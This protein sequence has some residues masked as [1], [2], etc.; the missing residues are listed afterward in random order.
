MPTTPLPAPAYTASGVSAPTFQVQDLRNLHRADYARAN[1]TLPFWTTLAEKTAVAK[2]ACVVLLA[3][4][5]VKVFRAK[6]DG[7]VKLS[8]FKPGSIFSRAAF[9]AARENR[10]VALPVGT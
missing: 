10:E 9:Q 2:G 8:N 1:R 6:P 7:K 5:T 3:D 4:D